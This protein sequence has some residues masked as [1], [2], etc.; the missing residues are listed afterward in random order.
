[1][2]ACKLCSTI[3]KHF[4][5]CIE[6]YVCKSRFHIKCL[7]FDDN[8]VKVF[9]KY[10]NFQFVCDECL[11][12]EGSSKLDLLTE[13]VNKCV[14]IV[15]EQSQIITAQNTLIK[16]LKNTNTVELGA[17]TNDLP[18]SYSEVTK[19]SSVILRPKN[20]NQTVSDIKKDLFTNIDPIASK[21]A[22]SNI[23][24]NRSG[25]VIITCD[26]LEDSTRIKGLI[27]D[28]LS[29]YNVKDLPL[30]HP[31]V[32]I[33]HIDSSVSQDKLLEYI[34]SQNKSLFSKNFNCVLKKFSPLRNNTTLNQA[35]LEVDVASYRN[36]LAAG[37]LLIGYDYCRVWDAVD[38]RR[39]F[40][41]SGFHHLSRQC[42]QTEPIC[43]RCAGHHCVKDCT[44]TTL[45]CIN[46]SALRDEH[47]D[48][49]C[50]HAAWDNSK[51][52]TYKSQL[53]TFKSRVLSLE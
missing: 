40:N 35:L 9:N 8:D 17:V 32:R 30:L 24:G 41:C 1:M 53:A 36:I 37:K 6:C 21:I 26:S 31:R 51:C 10:N 52:T 45:K 29:G 42:R 16:D 44:S 20:E 13:S 43:P 47:P 23:K 4:D 39:C 33:S 48:I 12:I 7:K 38:L 3:L 14:S 28:R 27:S 34:L 22:I 11:A 19:K 15:E 46:C 49:D 25:G 5:K 50:T 2:P 18:L